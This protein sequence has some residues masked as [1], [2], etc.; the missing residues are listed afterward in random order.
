MGHVD[1]DGY[2]VGTSRT[3]DVSQPGAREPSEHLTVQYRHTL[4]RRQRLG[5]R[6]A[7][8]QP[9]R[10]SRDVTDCD[11][12][13]LEGLDHREAV[14]VRRHHRVHP[15]IP[16]VLGHKRQRLLPVGHEQ[17][18]TRDQRQATSIDRRPPARPRA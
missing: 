2:A 16:Q 14:E 5:Q 4:A 15:A 3:E 12:L 1:D 9:P 6:V 11:A 10:I 8:Q 17:G 13:E 7:V 18:P